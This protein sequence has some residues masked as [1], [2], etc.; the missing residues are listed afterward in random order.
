MNP[1]YKNGGHIENV[2][3]LLERKELLDALKQRLE[4]R[5]NTV[6]LGV[7]GIGKRA[8][9][10]VF[11]TREFR[12]RMA[13]ESHTLISA[14]MELD[15]AL[16]SDDIYEQLIGM[17]YSAVRILAQCDRADEKKAIFEEMD[18]IRGRGVS[19]NNQFSQMIDLLHDSYGYHMVFVVEHFEKFT[20][21]EHVT[22][23]HHNLMRDLLKK[24]QYVVATNCDL[25]QDSLPRGVKGSM[26]LTAFSGNELVLHGLSEAAC[27]TYI[28]RHLEGN[29]I[30][31]SDRLITNLSRMSGGIPAL[32]GTAAYWAYE[33]IAKTGSENDLK[34]RPVLMQDEYVLSLLGHWCRMLTDSQLKCIEEIKANDGALLSEET[35]GAAKTLAARGFLKPA[36]WV[37]DGHRFEY[38][39][40][41]DFNSL[42]LRAYCEDMRRVREDAEKNPLRKGADLDA[43]LNRIIGDRSLT[44]EERIQLANMIVGDMSDVTRAVDLSAIPED[45]ELSQYF[46]SRGFL[47]T[48]DPVAA[49]FVVSGIN[50]CQVNRNQV[51]GDFAGSYIFFCKAL[52]AHLYSTLAVV[53]EAAFG[54]YQVENHGKY[55]TVAE[56]RRNNILLGGYTHIL[57]GYNHPLGMS[58]KQVFA[59]RLQLC[60]I[61]GYPVSFWDTYA[62]KL[63]RLTAIRNGCPHT[64]PLQS[65]EG[66]EMLQILFLSG[67]E[68]YFTQSTNLYNLMRE[69]GKL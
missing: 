12:I 10:D 45:Q 13:T 27:A 8:L 4:Q 54:N 26:Y 68:N 23:E 3:S 40:R 2:D 53:M 56:L 22:M 24:S 42:V 63:D 66:R 67:D 7:E 51:T 36:T 29:A 64:D 31:F 38:P 43:C 15:P 14:V 28:K 57:N 59:R 61:E 5:V 21:S 41:F 11:F 62:Q 17:C 58:N 18:E 30:R 35:K 20:A 52:E 47:D 34:L 1:F 65:D 33:H 48:L 37:E 9:L 39:D 46:I 69:Q 19:V 60:G 16:D 6:I 55:Q 25:D 44:K 49:R 32:L 50:M